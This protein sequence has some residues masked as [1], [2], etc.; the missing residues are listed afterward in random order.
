MKLYRLYV[1]R[2][3]CYKSGKTIKPQGVM[4][5][6]TAAPNPKL[7]R[8]VGP[9]D[10]RLGKNPYDNHW[11][12]P[13]PEGRQI[14][15]HAFIGKLADG[16]IATYQILPWTMRGW[17]CAK[18][19]NGSG[20]DTHIGFEVC[21]DDHKDKAYFQA[22]YKEA[23]ELCVYLCKEFGLSA[24][25]VI[26]HSEGHKKGIAS[27]H[28]DITHWLKLNGLSMKDFRRAVRDGLKAEAKLEAKKEVKA[29]DQK[30]AQTQAQPDK[31]PDELPGR[32]AAVPAADL[33]NPL[34]QGQPADSAKEPPAVTPAAPPAVPPAKPPIEA[35]LEQR[36]LA[37]EQ[38]KELMQ[39]QQEAFKAL[40]KGLLNEMK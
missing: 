18:G 1:T 8:Y 33:P 10:G 37:K 6:S 4:V 32:G 12:Q 40:V 29:N 39:Q 14:C 13:R 34:P 2:N 17:H 21:E 22:V 9:D 19:P 35:Y 30:N 31:L 24:D 11:N 5:H 27:D 15:C 7:S 26:D 20:N 25:S 16:S 3:E 36:E 28:G 38:V 23:V